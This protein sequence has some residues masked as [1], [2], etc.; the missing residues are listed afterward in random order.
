MKK[1][2]VYWGLSLA[3]H[4][5]R[6]QVSFGYLFNNFMMKDIPRADPRFPSVPRSPYLMI[7]RY[8]IVKKRIA[9][10]IDGWVSGIPK[11][12]QHSVFESLLLL[13][14]KSSSQDVRS[15][16]DYPVRFTRLID[17][18]TKNRLWAAIAMRTS[19]L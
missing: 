13:L 8:K 10:V 18:L 14:G 1:D 16:S 12:L 19:I 5:I 15:P 2:S 9:Q 11:E 6:E 4:E 17:V 7:Y 3:F